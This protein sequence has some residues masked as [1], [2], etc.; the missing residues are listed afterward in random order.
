MTGIEVD[1]EAVKPEPQ[2]QGRHMRSPVAYEVFDGIHR[3]T[4]A[5]ARIGCTPVDQQRERQP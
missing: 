5:C 2:E 3:E 1:A 4:S